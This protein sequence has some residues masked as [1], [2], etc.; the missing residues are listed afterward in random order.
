MLFLVLLPCLLLSAQLLLNTALEKG[1][2]ERFDFIVDRWRVEDLC[3]R[4]NAV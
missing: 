4:E 2:N 3:V 1:E